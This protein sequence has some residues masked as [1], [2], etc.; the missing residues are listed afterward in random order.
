MAISPQELQETLKKDSEKFEIEI[1]RL[2]R[3]KS[4]GYNGAIIIEAPNRM[5]RSHFE[6]I[7]NKYISAG[8]KEVKWSLEGPSVYTR[9][10]TLTFKS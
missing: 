4:P 6:F 10:V 8:W 1:D 9:Y 7:K 5:T 3:D 2:L